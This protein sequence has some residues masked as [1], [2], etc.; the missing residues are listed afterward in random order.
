MT[1]TKKLI[2]VALPLEAINIASAREKSIRH[3]HPG[4]LHDGTFALDMGCLHVVEST[5]TEWRGNRDEAACYALADLV[6]HTASLK[7]GAPP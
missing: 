7:T 4:T 2:E 5:L 1:Y 6:A 3:G